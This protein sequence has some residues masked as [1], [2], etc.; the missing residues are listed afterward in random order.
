MPEITLEDNQKRL[1]ENIH[2]FRKELHE[3]ALRAKRSVQS[4]QT[5]VVTKYQSTSVFSILQEQGFLHIGESRVLHAA[6]KKEEI[7]QSLSPFSWHLIG[8]LQKNKIKKALY[9]FSTLQVVDSL[10]L[11]RAISKEK[12]VNKKFFIQI[13]PLNEDSKRGFDLNSIQNDEILLELRQL[14]GSNIQGFM[15]MAPDRRVYGDARVHEAFS[16]TEKVYYSVKERAIF[17]PT[18]FSSLSMGMSNDFE[19]AL[20][21]GATHIRIGSKIFDGLG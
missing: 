4:I 16:M 12:I 3:A 10:D 11:A 5:I 21:Y 9:C 19:I 17:D 20:L 2:L 15:A 7:E 13:N 18:A 8:S 14:L 1:I 6:R